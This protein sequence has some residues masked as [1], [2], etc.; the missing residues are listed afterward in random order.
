MKKD[1][2]KMI[3]KIAA[4]TTIG[5]AIVIRDEI[6]AKYINELTKQIS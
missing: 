5:G 1:T 6:R 3:A 4:I 2:K